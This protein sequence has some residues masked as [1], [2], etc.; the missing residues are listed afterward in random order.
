[1]LLWDVLGRRVR[2][3]EANESIEKERALQGEAPVERKAISI[4]LDQLTDEQVAAVG[5]YAQFIK[6]PRKL[7]RL[8]N[9]VRLLKVN[10]HIDEDFENEAPHL[11]ALLAQVTIATAAPDLYTEWVSILRSLKVGGILIRDCVANAEMLFLK[12]EGDVIKEVLKTFE[13]HIDSSAW[14][15]NGAEDLLEHA[16]L[17]RRFSFAV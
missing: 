3:D 12:P 15:A 2:E 9:V 5:S 7:L 14:F 13:Q 10:G 6:S 16:P 4:K 11:H 1:M 8:A 17:A